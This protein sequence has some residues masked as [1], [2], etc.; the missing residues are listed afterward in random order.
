M[1]VEK[2]QYFSLMSN[3]GCQKTEKQN[4]NPSI[5]F[6]TMYRNKVSYTLETLELFWGTKNKLWNMVKEKK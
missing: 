4:K 1:R 2:K 6:E 5:Y 3:L